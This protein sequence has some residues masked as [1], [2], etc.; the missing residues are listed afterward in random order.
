MQYAVRTEFARQGI[1]RF[2][3]TM[4]EL[5]G[6][7]SLQDRLKQLDLA[8]ET[9]EILEKCWQHF[10]TPGA[11]Q[12][13]RLLAKVKFTKYI[14]TTPDNL[15]E[16]A[17]VA[18]GRHPVHW[19]YDPRC[20]SARPATADSNRAGDAPLLVHLYGSFERMDL[21][22]CSED[23][24]FEYLIDV[25]KQQAQAKSDLT[26]SF[27]NSSLIFLGFHLQEWDFRVLL[28]SIMS[29]G[30][31]A[32]AKRERHAHVAVQVDPS[33]A[34]TSI[35]R[36]EAK[37]FLEKYFQLANITIFWGSM[38]DFLRELIARLQPAQLANP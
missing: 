23:N 4:P 13:H 7:K 1:R 28:R 21:L 19:V 14:T 26:E 37:R 8:N 24:Y 30:G 12:A 29:L 36:S 20:Q 17:L 35:Q 22:V 5:L 15:L 2:A 11:P 34:R 16:K 6:G 18:A 9:P 31:F 27:T 33:E 32:H 38:E 10:D 3:A 25:E